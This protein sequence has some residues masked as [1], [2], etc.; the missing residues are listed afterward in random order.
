MFHQLNKQTHVAINFFTMESCV[1]GHH[2]S[3]SFW[4]PTLGEELWGKR[5]ECNAHDQHAVS[6]LDK[7]GA[8]V[9]HIL[10]KISAAC[11]L[12]L[13]KNGNIFCTATGKR[14]FLDLPQGGLEVPCNLKFEG[15]AKY[16]KNMKKL[17]MPSGSE[18]PCDERPP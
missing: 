3:K 12:F 15:D 4:S 1:R 13:Q 5:E 9:G 6:L 10:R 16:V 7:E 8:V 17:L 2:V 18:A 14:R 11:S